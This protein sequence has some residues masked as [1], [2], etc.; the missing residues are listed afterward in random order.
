MKTMTV[1]RN[2]LQPRPQGDNSHSSSSSSHNAKAMS[3]QGRRLLRM[4]NGVALINVGLIAKGSSN[5]RGVLWRILTLKTTLIL[6]TRIRSNSFRT[7]VNPLAD[8][9]IS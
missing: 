8:R 4:Q 5:L 7:L 3:L 1:T 6:Q 2:E 9:L